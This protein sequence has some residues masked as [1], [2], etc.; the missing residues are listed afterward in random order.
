MEQA[1]H[2]IAWRSIADLCAI[3]KRIEAKCAA[4]RILAIGLTLA[5]ANTKGGPPTARA[6]SA[7]VRRRRGGHD[8]RG[9]R[10]ATQDQR[11]QHLSRV[12]GHRAV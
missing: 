7:D 6:K 11:R 12:A 1:G 4:L 9:Y 10:G 5:K 3:V 8:A 2:S